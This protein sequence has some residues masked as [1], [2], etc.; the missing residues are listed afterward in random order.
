MS[1]NKVEVNWTKLAG[2]WAAIISLLSTL[3]GAVAYIHSNVSSV[4]QEA[5]NVH[6]HGY[7]SPKTNVSHSDLVDRISKIEQQISTLETKQDADYKDLFEAYW[8]L[9]GYIAAD[10]ESN[11]KLKAAA[12]AF[13]RKQFEIEALRYCNGEQCRSKKPYLQE[14]FR[15]AIRTPWSER[16][17]LLRFAR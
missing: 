15:A 3:G 6:D 12:A 16:E 5:V 11:R 1:P 8:H 10:T 17:Y 13:Y 9:I 7:P 2:I 14:A 4:A